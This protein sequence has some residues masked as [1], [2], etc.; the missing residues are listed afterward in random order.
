VTPLSALKL[1]EISKRSS[2]Y[3]LLSFRMAVLSYLL[4][5]DAAVLIVVLFYLAEF[6]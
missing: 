5:A 4:K 1:V 6:G 2:S 3:F